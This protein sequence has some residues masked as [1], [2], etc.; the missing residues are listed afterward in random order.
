M[1]SLVVIRH[2][3]F[4]GLGS[5][6]PLFKE[7]GY[8]ISYREAGKDN[9]LSLEALN[10]DLLVIC[11][12]PISVNEESLYPFLREELRVV[13]HRLEKKRP[14]L[15]I[16]LGAQI[17]AKA[18]GSKIYP[19]SKKE[20]GWFPLDLSQEGAV[21]PLRFLGEEPARVFHWHGETF[22]LPPSTTLLASTALCP[23]QA[24]SYKGYALGLQFH[25]EVLIDELEQW[26][27]GHTC[28]LSHT[29][30]VHLSHLR[31]E[32]KRWGPLLKRQGA[33]FLKEW[34]KNL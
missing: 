11:G 8:S 7:M 18:L 2:V 16:C 10:P 31:S 4:E 15:G 12:G 5:F 3:M 27:I 25:P 6:E 20:I 1:K 32:A 29:K 21:S 28:E 13:G 34:V 9:L 33:L 24:F 23:H 19:A 17:L 26:Y 30:S 22:D 14:L